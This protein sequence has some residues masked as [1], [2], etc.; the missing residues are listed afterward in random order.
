M[1]LLQTKTCDFPDPF[2]NQASRADREEGEKGEGLGRE[3]NGQ[4]SSSNEM[5]GM[6]VKLT[7]SS[8]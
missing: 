1:T 8:F 2:S 4:Q 3:G 5:L 7:I 6:A